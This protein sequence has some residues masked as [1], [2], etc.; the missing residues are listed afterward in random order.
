MPLL[1]DSEV[2]SFLSEVFDSLLMKS[3][4][5]MGFLPVLVSCL[6]KD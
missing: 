5:T 3:E 6:I 4:N 1:M 2:L